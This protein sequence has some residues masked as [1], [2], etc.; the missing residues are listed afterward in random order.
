MF[1]KCFSRLTSN[2]SGRASHRERGLFHWRK[3]WN[4]WLKKILSLNT[5]RILGKQDCRQLGILCEAGISFRDGLDLIEDERNREVLS[6]LRAKMKEGQPLGEA[7]TPLMPAALQADFAALIQ[8]QPFSR[9]LA[10]TLALDEI[11]QKLRRERAKMLTY[12][13]LV[14][15]GSVVGLAVFNELCFPPLIA[16]SASFG[17][18]TAA[19]QL[20]QGGIRTVLIVMGTAI[21]GGAGLLLFVLSSLTRKLAA[22]VILIRMHAAGLIR[23]W[24]GLD[25]ARY[26]HCCLKEG[27]ATRATL[28][29]LQKMEKK[30]L[31][32]LISY[33]VEQALLNGQSL[34]RAA[35]SEYLDPSFAR[36]LNAACRSHRMQELLESYIA[37]GQDRLVRKQKRLAAALQATAYLLIALILIL[38]YQILLLPLSVMSQL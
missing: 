13:C 32:R 16:M 15:G 2:G 7:L 30:P 9:A 12:P 26:F 14:L 27:C 36:F 8:V 23:E 19:M 28:Q 20:A 6:R 18:S 24:L 33:H 11:Q 38:V 5:S 37:A 22:Y 10:M 1:M 35:A 17:A 21:A 31:I 34:T 3:E 29:I 4:G 25:F